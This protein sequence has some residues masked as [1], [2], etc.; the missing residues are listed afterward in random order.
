M[1]Y[2]SDPMNLVYTFMVYIALQVI[3]L[4]LD[5]NEKI[6]V[7]YKIIFPLVTAFIIFMLLSMQCIPL[8]R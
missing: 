3:T 4:I 5:H 2:N 6:E 1:H 8:R 7:R